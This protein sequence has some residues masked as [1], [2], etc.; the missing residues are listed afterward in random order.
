MP[1]DRVL[2]SQ[3]LLRAPA[4]RDIVEYRDEVRTFPGPRTDERSGDVRPDFAAVLAHEP[5]FALIGRVPCEQA[6]ARRE[7]FRDV[8]RMRHVADTPLQ[9]FLARVAREIAE[10]RI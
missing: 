3:H 10:L 6:I 7:A 5:R 8:V 4:L 2:Q 1:S 9:R